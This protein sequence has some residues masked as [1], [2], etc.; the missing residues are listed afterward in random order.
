MIK[1]LI[2]AVLLSSTVDAACCVQRV[3]VKRVVQ[4]V[5]PVV[6]VQT[7]FLVAPPS[8]YGAAQYSPPSAHPAP[9]KSTSIDEQI[10]VQLE[11][12]AA[13]LG[14]L[15]ARMDR[16][17]HGGNGVVP[18]DDV[19]PVDDPPPDPIPAAPLVIHE[20]CGKCHIGQEA[21]GDFDL[22]MLTIANRNLMARAMVANGK[23]PVDAEGHPVT[24]TPDL[25]S[26]LLRALEGIG[27][28]Q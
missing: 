21:K 13:A 19:V 25:R 26:E 7:L 2:G 18:M 5:I 3:I 20:T 12:I 11:R 9:V 10:V 1:G 14:D 27:D 15:E 24:I 22:S 28:D 23:M 16:L 17:E 6:P 4:Q 8:Y